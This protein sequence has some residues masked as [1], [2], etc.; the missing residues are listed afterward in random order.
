[1]RKG[2]EINMREMLKTKK[3]KRKFPLIDDFIAD[4][5]RK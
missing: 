2:N 3:Y 4:L 1:M 5:C